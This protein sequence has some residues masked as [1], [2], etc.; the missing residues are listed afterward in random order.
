MARHMKDLKKLS[1]VATFSFLLAPSALADDTGW[2]NWATGDRFGVELSAYH[3]NT[4][5]DLKV[6]AERYNGPGIWLNL[7][8]VLGIEDAETTAS[9]TAFWR[10][11]ERNKLR[12]SYF[13]L[14][15]DGLESIDI[16]LGTIGGGASTPPSRPLSMFRLIA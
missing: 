16:E 14:D 11:T 8:D 4:K 2:S 13:D 6:E 1:I 15:R 5:T 10:I 3:V 9:M 12:Y 7:E